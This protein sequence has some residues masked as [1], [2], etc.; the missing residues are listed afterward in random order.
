MLKRKKNETKIKNRK[1]MF[2]KECFKEAF[3]ETSCCV[4]LMKSLDK[5]TSRLGIFFQEI[6][7]HNFPQNERDNFI[8]RIGLILVHRHFSMSFCKYFVEH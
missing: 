6:I 2:G 4:S 7:F 1:T 3:Q 5:L 8:I